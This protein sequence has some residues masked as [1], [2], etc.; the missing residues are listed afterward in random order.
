MVNLSPDMV[1]DGAWDSGYRYH[2]DTIKTFS[3]VHAWQLSGIPVLPAIGPFK[4]HLGPDK[5]GSIYNRDKEEVKPGYH[6]VV[7]EDYDIIAELT[8]TTR[9]GFHRYTYPE[10][11]NSYIYFDFSTELGPSETE[12]GYVKKVSDTEIEG[13][14]VMGSTIRRPKP[15]KVFFVAQFD[16]P[17]EK[18]G[19][20]QY[21]EPV[22]IDN[23]IEGESTGAWV[24]FSTFENETRKMK[25]GISYTSI[26]QARLNMSTELPNWDFYDV[27]DQ[28]QDEWNNWLGKIEVE[29][30]T[31]KER[32]RFY[33]DLWKAL[34]GRRIVSD[35]NGKYLD[36]TGDEPR[37][38]QIPLDEHG[39]PLFNHHNSDSFWGAQWSINTLWHL[40]Y[41][42]ITDDFVNSMIMMYDDG[43]LIPRGPS[44][45]NY[46]YVMTGA[47]SSPFIVSAYLKGIR[48]YDVEKA[49]EG[50]RKNHMPGG[51]MSKAGY[52]HDTFKAG[53]IEEYMDLGYVPYPL[54]EKQYG[55]HQAG[56]GQ[57]LEYSYQDWALSQL[58]A[59]LGKKEDFDLFSERAGN[60]R[61]LWNDEKGWMWAKDRQGNWKES[62]SFDYLTY[63]GPWVESNAAQYTWWVPHDLKGL[64]EM[65]G[66]REVF[67]SKLNSSFEQAQKHLFTSG[68]AHAMEQ[69]LDYRRVYINYGNQQSMQ[70]A[71]LFNH[72]EAPWLTQYWTRRVVEDVYS[73][74]TFDRG[75]SGDEDQGFMGSLAVLLKM[76]IFSVD[77][78]VNRDPYYEIGSPTFDKITI[79]LDQ[80]YY[81]GGKFVIEANNNGSNNYYI[82][83]A[84]LNGER[85]DKS[86]FLHD[87]LMNGGTLRLEMGSEPNKEWGSA[88]DQAPPSMSE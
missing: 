30:G 76:G 2:K 43:G 31:E 72:S 62:E 47:P 83:S 22:D 28:S 77:G 86:W 21:G 14:A 49:W 20:W 70:T 15:V 82:Q 6:K 36:M 8:S 26:D 84:T 34:Q 55:F 38:G 53:G 18:F 75:Y 65:M 25:V 71:W 1:I 60:Y 81:P 10:S 54:Y 4:G 45:G 56:A 79:H 11:E 78:G 74:L 13:Y 59:E 87:D 88:P 27:V 39:N 64:A 66:G 68:I 80:N 9:A 44:G 41:P 17:F 24:Q 50:L 69:E 40:V 16:Q 35:V 51:L 85:H 37:I 46:T 19:G 32:R 73:D 3:H 5:Y 63:G 33:T 58:A 61:N 57:T 67:T 52:E 48:G 12:K 42:K 29:G 7:L 23:V